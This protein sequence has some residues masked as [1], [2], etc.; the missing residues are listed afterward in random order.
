MKMSLTKNIA[1]TVTT[2]ILSAALLMSC[3]GKKQFRMAG[4]TVG[5]K[6][7]TF[8]VVMYTP[9]GVET[10]VLAT[11]SGHFEYAHPVPDAD[12]P[13]FIEFYTHDY[14]LL[15]LAMAT[16]GSKLDIT[17]D[18]DG[19][20]GFRVT[21]SNDEN[22]KA[23]GDPLNRL[24]SESKTTDN[25][26][27]AEFVKTHPDSPASY[28]LLTTLYDCGDDKRTARGLMESISAEARPAYYDNGFATLLAVGAGAPDVVPATA[29]LCAADTIFDYD[30]KSYGATLIA[31]TVDNNERSDSVVPR[32]QELGKDSKKKE[33]LVLEHSLAGDTTAWRRM[34]RNDRLALR[35]R[36]V[37]RQEELNPG[38]KADVK[39]PTLD[40]VSVWTGNNTSAPF[41][42]NFDI[43]GLPYFVVVDRKGRV[44]Y[45]GP[46]M[47]AAADTL[48]NLSTVKTSKK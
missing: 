19:F 12:H 18:A 21:D 6:E 11:R 17:L 47:A 16:G 27:I 5:G 24:L 20:G 8:R 31:F 25:A 39:E 41:A 37:R 28:A 40:W 36:E 48:S 34:L 35:R 45:G 1:L 7:I 9:R 43:G 23:F 29:M 30:P 14:K 15:G 38:R 32:L 33:I 4:D 44:R 3:S 26:A 10:E 13:V 2:L 42:N 46:S 22:Q